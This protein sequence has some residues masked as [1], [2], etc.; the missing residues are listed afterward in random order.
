M[1]T[2]EPK[3]V[4]LMLEAIEELLYKIA[5]RLEELKG[6]PLTGERKELTKKQKA[7]E[8]IQHKL[9]HR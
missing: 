4:P 5:L 6:G 2:I 3:H 8:D 9:L 1:P 7:L